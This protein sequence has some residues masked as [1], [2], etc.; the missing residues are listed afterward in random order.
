MV[1]WAGPEE[2][3]F[4]AD[5]GLVAHRAECCSVIEVKD[6]VSNFGSVNAFIEFDISVFK[7]RR[8]IRGESTV[9]W[10]WAVLWSQEALEEGGGDVVAE[11]FQEVEVTAVDCSGEDGSDGKK[12]Q[13][14]VSSCSICSLSTTLIEVSIAYRRADMR[15]NV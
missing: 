14:M 8:K 2:L 12:E 15:S 13:M 9:E 10:T 5:E 1:G 4:V 7:I 11:E 6:S 3:T